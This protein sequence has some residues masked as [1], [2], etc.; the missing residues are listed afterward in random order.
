MVFA[1]GIIDELKEGVKWGDCD[2]YKERS[3]SAIHF[4]Q[5]HRNLSIATS[6][7]QIATPLNPQG[8]SAAT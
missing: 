8:S 3:N 2:G 5:K 7:Q 4:E 1:L 6:S